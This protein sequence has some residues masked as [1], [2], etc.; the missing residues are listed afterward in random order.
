MKTSKILPILLICIIALLYSCNGEEQ[1]TSTA[2]DR[3]RLFDYIIEKTK[4]REAFSPIKQEVMSFDP[5]TEMMAYREEMIAADTDQEL[6]NVLIKISNARRDRHLSVSPVDGG[7]LIDDETDQVAPLIFRV[8][9]TDEDNYFLF[10]GD[11]AKNTRSQWKMKKL[12]LNLKDKTE[13]SIQ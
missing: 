10:V 7:L 1:N 9:Y 11:Y 13:K 12:S 8:D 4:V 3:A 2:E 6:F 5:I